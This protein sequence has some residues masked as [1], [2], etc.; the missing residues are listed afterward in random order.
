MEFAHFHKIGSKTVV[1]DGIEKAPEAYAAMRK[2]VYRVV[3]RVAD[4]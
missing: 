4:E 3:I 2:G 1:F